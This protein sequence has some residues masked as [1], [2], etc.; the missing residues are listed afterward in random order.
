MSTATTLK[1]LSDALGRMLLT[2]RSTLVVGRVGEVSV[3]ATPFIMYA[4]DTF[5]PQGFTVT[6]IAGDK[7]DETQTVQSRATPVTF[8]VEVIGGEAAQDA[9]ACCAVLRQSQ[10]W[11]D[12]WGISGLAGV[13]DPINLSALETGTMR[14]R[15]QLRITLFATLELTN[16]AEVIEQVTIT[17]AD[18]T[19][20]IQQGVDP[21]GCD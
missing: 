18:R 19:I 2:V 10:R 11:L 6:E 7:P 16:A 15:W 12:L 20:T 13:S 4:V 9:W 17:T 14:Q 8:V 3:P 1:A 5:T 21:H